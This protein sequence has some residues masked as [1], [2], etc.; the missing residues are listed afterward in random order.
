VSGLVPPHGRSADE[1][2]GAGDASRRCTDDWLVAE[3]SS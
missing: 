2:E 1:V 3:D